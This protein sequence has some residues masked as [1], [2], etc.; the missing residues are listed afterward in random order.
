[1]SEFAGLQQ[2]RGMLTFFLNGPRTL[3]PISA[4]RYLPYEEALLYCQFLN[5]NDHIDWR[6]P[7][8]DELVSLTY[9][10]LS[11]TK[12]SWGVYWATDH[13]GALG[14]IMPPG[15]ESHDR[16]ST[17]SRIVRPVR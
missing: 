12:L 2:P 17:G 6:L 9:L 14:L 13:N 4:E 1:M 7:T 3:S 15:T 8:V 10:H 5:I 11:D 16:T